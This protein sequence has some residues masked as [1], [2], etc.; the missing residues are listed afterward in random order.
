MVAGGGT[1]PRAGRI[2][3]LKSPAGSRVWF[4]D[5]RPVQFQRDGG[6][7]LA[8]SQVRDHWRVDDEWWMETPLRRWYFDV[9][10]ANGG[11]ALFWVVPEDAGREGGVTAMP[12]R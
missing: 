6:P 12:A 1:P 3:A 2:R 7:V 11:L 5:G 10:L 9:V 8:V 4:R